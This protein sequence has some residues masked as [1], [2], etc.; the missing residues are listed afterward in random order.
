MLTIISYSTFK[1]LG[2]SHHQWCFIRT[3]L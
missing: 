1:E 2:V 3:Y